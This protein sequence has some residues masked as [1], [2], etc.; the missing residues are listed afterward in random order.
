MR[1][2]LDAAVKRLRRL[3][4]LFEHKSHVLD[5]EE[6]AQRVAQELGFGVE[7]VMKPVRPGDQNTGPR[8]QIALVLR[9][10]MKW[11]ASRIARALHCCERTAERWIA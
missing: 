11:A 7:I 6:E 1:I 9:K 3:E 10:R 4:V 8:Q 5:D 2:E